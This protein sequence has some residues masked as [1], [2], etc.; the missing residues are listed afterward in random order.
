[1]YIHDDNVQFITQ[2]YFVIKDDD[3]RFDDNVQFMTH[4]YVVIKDGIVHFD[5]NVQY[6]WRIWQMYVVNVRCHIKIK[7]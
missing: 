4:M 5:D 3:E 7:I 2:M 1:M 6:A